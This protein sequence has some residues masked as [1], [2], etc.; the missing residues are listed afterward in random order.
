MRERRQP[1]PSLV[2]RVGGISALVAGGLFFATVVYAF[3]VMSGFGF[4]QEMFDDRVLLV[5]WVADHACL[6]RGLWLLYFASQVFL[7]PVPLALYAL[8]RRDDGRR[9]GLAA[10]FALAG[11]AA[12]VMAMVG[13][14]VIYA[15]SAP[16][17]R[18]FVETSSSSPERAS[19]L[20]LGD[21]FADVGK[22][23]RLFSELLLGVW[24]GGT[25][26][27]LLCG[28]RSDAVGW[29]MLIIGGCTLCVAVLKIL[30]PLNPLEDFLGLL[31][32]GGYVVIG[33]RLLRE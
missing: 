25:G 26:A 13:L 2:L 17:A 22:E 3:G 24:L 29:S 14:V 31:L 4:T 7:L 16:I 10:P 27:A 8:V 30:D 9:S 12:V 28:T 1:D 6:Y 11:I 18:A 20:L 33:V 15:T 21:L 23:I 19:V 5:P 32:A